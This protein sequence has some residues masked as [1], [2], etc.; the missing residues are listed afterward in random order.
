MTIDLEQAIML[1]LDKKRD[2]ILQRHDIVI[3][4]HTEIH[5]NTIK[6]APRHLDQL[7]DRI[8]ETKLEMRSC[9]DVE[10]HDSLYAKLEAYERLA[11]FVRRADEGKPLDGQAY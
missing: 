5:V 4:R 6:N 7:K 9:D 8:K 10:Q 3:T 11:A 2:F 1:H